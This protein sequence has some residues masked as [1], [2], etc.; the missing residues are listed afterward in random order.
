MMCAREEIRVYVGFFWGMYDLCVVF[1][2]V[3]NMMCVKVL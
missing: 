2:G 3:F 1:L